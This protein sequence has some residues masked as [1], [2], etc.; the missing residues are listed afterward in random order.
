MA[1]ARDRAVGAEEGG[2]DAEY[3]G[4]SGEAAEQAAA[5][6]SVSGRGV[7]LGADILGVYTLPRPPNYFWSS[8]VPKASPFATSNFTLNPSIL[9]PRSH[10]PSPHP[11]SNC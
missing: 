5:A 10:T 2:H 11:K 1:E 3:A 8:G 7:V 9:T 4:V 6:V